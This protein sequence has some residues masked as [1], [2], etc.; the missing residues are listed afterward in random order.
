MLDSLFRFLGFDSLIDYL[1]IRVI[2][3]NSRQYFKFNIQSVNDH[4]SP[5]SCFKPKHQTSYLLALVAKRDVQ[6]FRVIL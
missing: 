2:L 3:Q 4:V 1:F 6:F 5:R